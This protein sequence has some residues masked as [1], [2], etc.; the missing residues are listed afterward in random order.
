M[1]GGIAR[2]KTSPINKHASSN[3]LE[4]SQPNIIEQLNTIN[5]SNNQPQNKDNMIKLSPANPPQNQKIKHK[6][7][8]DKKKV[9]PITDIAIFNGTLVDYLC[10]GG[11]DISIINETIFKKLKT[12][13]EIAQ[14]QGSL[15]HSCSGE[16]QVLAKLKLKNS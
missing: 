12:N 7:S 2:Y 13:N 8:K 16:I 10:D 5:T 14:Y 15:I 3:K 4:K 1:N 11:A 6:N 9:E